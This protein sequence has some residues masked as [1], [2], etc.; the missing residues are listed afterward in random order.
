MHNHAPLL[1]A[2]YRSDPHLD[3]EQA[4]AEQEATRKVWL[5]AP[6]VTCV[7]VHRRQT[8]HDLAAVLF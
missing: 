1:K 3:R 2:S 4:E 8:D 6:C 5:A 7:G